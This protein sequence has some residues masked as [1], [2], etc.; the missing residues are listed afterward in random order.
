MLQLVKV[1]LILIALYT[2]IYLFPTLINKILGKPNLF[3]ITFIC[4]HVKKKI[5]AKPVKNGKH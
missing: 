1:G 3:F 5:I 4:K 2:A